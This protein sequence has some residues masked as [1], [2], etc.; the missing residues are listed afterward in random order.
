MQNDNITQTIK[1][2]YKTYAEERLA[3]IEALREM[4][5]TTDQAIKIAIMFELREISD[6]LGSPDYGVM[7]LSLSKLSDCFSYIPPTPH[8][9]RGHQYLCS[10]MQQGESVLRNKVKEPIK[11]PIIFRK[12]PKHPSGYLSSDSHPSFSPLFLKKFYSLVKVHTWPIA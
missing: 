6:S 2:N 7:A 9:Q 5:Y 12:R 11:E 8:Q 10:L 1:E 4:G 3:P